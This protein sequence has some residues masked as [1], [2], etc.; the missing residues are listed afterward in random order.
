MLVQEMDRRRAGRS[1]FKVVRAGEFKAARFSSVPERQ[2]ADHLA[3]L[4]LP[5]CPHVHSVLTGG[6]WDRPDIVIPR[7]RVIVEFDGS[8]WHHGQAKRE[9]DWDK[10]QRLMREGW[11]VLRVRDYGLERMPQRSSRFAQV[12]VGAR[13][14]SA[15][16]AEAAL[17]VMGERGW[18]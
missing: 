17:R 7:A 16:V 4:G 5:A 10:S 18:W 3:A 11:R 13:W 14:G 6:R 15:Q 1:P 9:S 2:L 8:Y 12:K